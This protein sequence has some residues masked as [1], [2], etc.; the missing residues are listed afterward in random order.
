[1]TDSKKSR[2]IKLTLSVVLSVVVMG[3]LFTQIN[4][5]DVLE[6]LS[7][8]SLPW[9]GAGLIF[10]FCYQVLKTFRFRALISSR[11]DQTFLLFSLQCFHS[12]LNTALPFKLGEVAFVYLLKR[13]YQISVAE[14]TSVLVAARVLDFAFIALVFIS[15]GVFGWERFSVPYLQ[16]VALA[17]VGAATMVL[18]FYIAL[19]RLGDEARILR[20]FDKPK[21]GRRFWDMLSRNVTLLL[22]A[23]RVIKGHQYLISM[24]Y[25]M[26]MWTALYGTTYATAH[27]LRFQLS[28]DEA[29][30]IFLASF[31]FD[32]LPI[33]GIW[34][35]GTHEGEWTI[36]LLLLGYPQQSTFLL[37][38]GSHL[39]F[40]LNIFAVLPIPTIIWWRK[41]R[42]RD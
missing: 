33:K 17:M 22:H 9:I 24:I 40:L 36:G 15:L 26:L 11:Q 20:W 19:L 23:F 30:F 1:M 39:I 7:Q 35:F 32:F 27:A 31:P 5:N 34:D 12:F 3:F 13:G 6:L 38:V 21:R 29:L 28:L 8:A 14:G 41:W 18:V 4:L 42:R 25:S 2:W 10:F 16:F 37:A